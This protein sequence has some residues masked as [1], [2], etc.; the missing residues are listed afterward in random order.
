MVNGYT[1]LPTDALET[2]WKDTLCLPQTGKQC[3]C[4]FY[5]KVKNRKGLLKCFILE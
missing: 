1:W 4:E 5:D 2:A 3:D